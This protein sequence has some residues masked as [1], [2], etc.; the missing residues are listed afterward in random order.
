MVSEITICC[1]WYSI[2]CIVSRHVVSHIVYEA[3]YARRPFNSG[4]R[5]RERKDRSKKSMSSI[6]FIGPQWCT[7]SKQITFPKDVII[8]QNFFQQV[9]S[10]LQGFF[11]C[12]RNTNYSICSCSSM[13]NRYTTLSTTF[14][15]NE[16]LNI[17]C[18]SVLEIFTNTERRMVVTDVQTA[19]KDGCPGDG[20]SHQY[21]S[22]GVRQKLAEGGFPCCPLQQT[23][24]PI[25][26]CRFWLYRFTN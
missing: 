9:P 24:F 16:G 25:Q 7:S 11:Q 21:L 23:Y 15:S 3:I 18:R 2:G 8:S 13:Q 19:S 22:A 14:A 12:T 26:S 17:S 4:A 1:H 20:N 5:I 6:H 10:H